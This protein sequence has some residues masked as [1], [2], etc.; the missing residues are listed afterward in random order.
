[1]S[2]QNYEQEIAILRATLADTDRERENLRADLATVARERDRLRKAAV[3]QNQEIEQTLGAAL[4]YPRYCDNLESFPDAT[5]DDGVCVGDHVAETLAEEAAARIVTL[6]SGKGVAFPDYEFLYRELAD[7]QRRDR[8]R[9]DAARNAL[10][11]ILN[12][13]APTSAIYRVTREAL[14]AITNDEDE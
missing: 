11:N 6:Q 9:L 12:W 2:K 5:E 13:A 7:T 3:D 4:G 10:S 14:I 8:E 1:M